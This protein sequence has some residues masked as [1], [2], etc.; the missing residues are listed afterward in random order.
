LLGAILV[1]ETA[2]GRLSG[3]II[4]TEAYLGTGDPAS[5]SARGRTAR[6]ASMFVAAG[7]IYVYRIYGVH[8]CLNVVTGAEG[9]G[10]AV[11]LRALEPLE[12]LDAMRE[13]RGGVH[14]P[15]GVDLKGSVD[16]PGR[17]DDRKLCDGPGKLVQALGVTAD[18]DGAPFGV[19]R[20]DG[21]L[22]GNTRGRSG[23]LALFEGQ[24]PRPAQRVLRG[25]RVGITKGAEMPLRFRFA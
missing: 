20:A 24:R 11:L 1:H 6:N 25:P 18:Y 10:E 5:H 12:G 4:E 15:G 16:R 22:A 7:T 17:V 13:R 23:E 3:R 2:Q 21:T 19:A 8:L 9:V 14:R